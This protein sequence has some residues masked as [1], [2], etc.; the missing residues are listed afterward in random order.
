MAA[1]VWMCVFSMKARDFLSALWSVDPYLTVMRGSAHSFCSDTLPV[2]SQC[3]WPHSQ[4]VGLKTQKLRKK[5]V[6]VSQLPIYFHVLITAS[7]MTW[8]KS[9]K[10]QCAV[11]K[12]EYQYII[13]YYANKP[14][15][16]GTLSSELQSSSSVKRLA[17]APHRDYH[18]GPF[19]S[20]GCNQ[21]HAAASLSA[22]ALPQSRPAD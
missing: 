19:S 2:Y 5:T 17:W 20:G 6:T 9:I 15:F 10:D 8:D 11:H 13:I 22:E 1:G 3:C 16:L 7:Q 21:R 12:P 14:W 4:S 18:L